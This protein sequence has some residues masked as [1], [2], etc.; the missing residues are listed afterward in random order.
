MLNGILKIFIIPIMILNAGGAI[1]GGIWLAF[2][3]E[4]KLIAIGILLLFTLN[5]FLSFLMIPAI[6]ISGIAI[7]FGEKNRF[8]FN[9]FGYLSAIYTNI[10]IIATCVSAF[11]IC[12]SFYKETTIGL[13]LIPYLLWS[14][15]MALGPWQ[16]FASHEPENEFTAITLFSASI[17]YFLFLI[18]LFI[19]PIL[20]LIIIFLFG[21]V[22]V[23]LLP[24]FNMYIANKSLETIQDADA[25][26]KSD[27][28][29]NVEVES[30]P[31]DKEMME[32][33]YITKKYNK[34]IQRQANDAVNYNA[35]AMDNAKLDRTIED[36]NKA[37]LLEPNNAVT[38]YRRGLAYAELGQ[39]QRA[40]EDYNEAIHLNPNYADALY[41]RLDAY[42]KLKK[43]Q[44]N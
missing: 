15:G 23:I 31:I 12:T 10:L 25:L 40:I 4:W 43:N 6:L 3:G 33:E 9:L 19:S 37:I 32:K 29:S 7:K 27:L 38:F 2:I 21:I 18:S 28:S 39:Y 26:L 42:E 24:I 8:L 41:K 34:A 11:Y 13:S 22:Q 16:F 14:W 17:F 20:S 36:Y 30:P 44:N 35:R 1:V 5:W